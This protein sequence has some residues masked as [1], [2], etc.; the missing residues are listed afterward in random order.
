M[1][2]KTTS[3]DLVPRDKN[4]QNLLSD[5]KSIITKGQYK[6]YKAVDNIRVQTYWQLG[7]RIVREELKHEDRA[8]YGKYL[9]DNLTVDLDIGRRLLYRIVQF[10]RTYPIVS[11]LRTQLSWA[12]YRELIVIEDSKE[13]EF[14]EN[15]II[16]NSWSV[17]DLSR[18]IK[19]K[20]Y[21]NTPK[22]DIQAVFQTKLPAFS[23]FLSTRSYSLGEAALVYETATDRIHI[24]FTQPE[25]VIHKPHIFIVA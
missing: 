24:T 6:A 14:Y 12:H 16:I 8:D 11:T 17:R 23:S 4:Y 7:E 5:L 20:L 3:K 19:A 15:K 21:E 25:I 2:K 1:P 10:Y 13:R 9:V 22:K 18:Q